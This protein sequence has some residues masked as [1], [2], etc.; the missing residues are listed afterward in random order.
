MSPLQKSE[1]TTTTNSRLLP[2]RCSKKISLSRRKATTNPRNRKKDC[3]SHRGP[4]TKRLVTQDQLSKNRMRSKTDP[5]CV[6]QRKEKVVSSQE[7]ISEREMSG[8]LPGKEKLFFF[9]LAD[10]PVL[11]NCSSYRIIISLSCPPPPPVRYKGG[12]GPVHTSREFIRA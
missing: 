3:S 8:R 4:E 6:P 7:N 11:M 12:G 5:A 10:N 9:F 1:E 2:K